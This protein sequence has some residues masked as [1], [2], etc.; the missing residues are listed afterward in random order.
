MVKTNLTEE[1]I[2]LTGTGLRQRLQEEVA[3]SGDRLVHGSDHIQVQQ[4][5]RTSGKTLAQVQIHHADG[6]D[7]TGQGDTVDLTGSRN[8]GKA[9]L[10]SVSIDL[11]QR[12]SVTPQAQAIGGSIG[13][14]NLL[15]HV[16]NVPQAERLAGHGLG[17]G[18]NRLHQSTGLVDGGIRSGLVEGSLNKGKLNIPVD[19]LHLRRNLEVQFIDGIGLLVGNIQARQGAHVGLLG[20][21]NAYGLHE[22]LS[23]I[24]LLGAGN[25]TRLRCRQRSG[26]TDSR[27]LAAASGVLLAGHKL[28]MIGG[29]S[30]AAD[31]GG[32]G[33]A[34][35]TLIEEHTGVIQY[36][37]TGSQSVGHK[38]ISPL[39]VI[40]P[41]LRPQPGLSGVYS[42]RQR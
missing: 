22:N 29:L 9:I 14:V 21:G 37:E 39:L 10:N 41:W 6:S 34:G 2:L 25:H 42:R 24:G 17:V 40:Y 31:D 13:T 15:H 5:S 12:G 23:H 32:Q 26:F 1:L 7:H 27:L 18:G 19:L 35:I 33:T 3:L 4:Q 28:N 11:E 36:P 30:P 20:I 38:S 16:S 8:H